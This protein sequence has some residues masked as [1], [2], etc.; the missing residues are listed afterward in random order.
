MDFT[1]KSQFN[2]SESETIGNFYKMLANE[3]YSPSSIKPADT[4]G[5]YTLHHLL[6]TTVRCISECSP[7]IFEGTKKE[8]EPFKNQDIPEAS[9]ILAFI[10]LGIVFCSRIIKRSTH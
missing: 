4:F 9:H 1:Q 10:V 3:Q 8:F 6:E 2:I 7:K 5:G